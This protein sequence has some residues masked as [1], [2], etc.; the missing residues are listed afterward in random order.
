MAA[1]RY[2][3]HIEASYEWPL[4]LVISDDGVPRVLTGWEA[5]L[6]IRETIAGPLLKA[7]TSSPAAGITVTAAAGQLDILLT[8]AETEALGITLGVYELELY[9]PA[10]ATKDQRLL[11]G[12]V[13]VKPPV[14]RT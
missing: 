9:K 8:P 11:E 2:D 13:I 10:D 7:L 6:H 5:R 3:L 1:G 14:V 12:E 4:K